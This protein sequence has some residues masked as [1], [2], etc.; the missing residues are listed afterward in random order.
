MDMDKGV[1]IDCGN[2]GGLGAGGQGEKNWDNYNR[3]K[4]GS[5]WF[6]QDKRLESWSVT[7]CQGGLAVYNL[8]A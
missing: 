5:L 2:G 1:G 3:G 7:I 8:M 6:K 4:K